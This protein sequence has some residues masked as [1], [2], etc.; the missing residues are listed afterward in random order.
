MSF[1]IGMG[2]ALKTERICR[3]VWCGI[4]TSWAKR[5]TVRL[6]GWQHS[7]RL[8]TAVALNM[9]I[10][11]FGWYDWI[12][13]TAGRRSFLAW[14]RIW[15]RKGVVLCSRFLLVNFPVISWGVKQVA[16]RHS[17][18]AFSLAYPRLFL[19][20]TSLD[21]RNVIHPVFFVPVIARIDDIRNVEVN[22]IQRS[23]PFKSG[24]D[25]KQ[26]SIPSA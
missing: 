25:S 18:S 12:F 8:R 22:A 13:L 26:F 4:H 1:L 23:S 14:L 5:N 7:T 19:T 9:F 24:V 10:N 3:C 21:L 17:R 11:W 16:S 2:I 15:T 6:F 20:K